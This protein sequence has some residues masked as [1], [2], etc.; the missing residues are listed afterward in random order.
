M[1][2]SPQPA[3][4]EPPHHHYSPKHYHD[5]R[6]SFSGRASTSHS[7]TAHAHPAMRRSRTMATPQYADANPWQHVAKTYAWVLEQQFARMA[8]ENDETVQ[9][10]HQQQ[11]RDAIREQAAYRIV[12][13]GHRGRHAA[14]DVHYGDPYAAME[15]AARRKRRWQREAELMLEEEMQRLQAY[16]RESE[17]HREAFE[18]RRLEE[19]QARARWEREREA[20]RSRRQEAE[21]EAQS[22]YESRWAEL[23]STS[24]SLGFCDIPWPTFAR[25]RSLDDITTAKVTRFVLSP[26][27]PGETRREKVRNALRRWHPD[28]FGRVLARVDEEDR[29]MVEEGVGIVV[30]CLNSLLERESQ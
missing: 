6:A 11:A 5:D 10:I 30:R 21:R 12:A 24:E 9:W 25:P 20:L 19:E 7:S 22:E 18:K 15:E 3:Y 26:L 2:A 23:S 16:R 14:E 4:Y 27:Q 13:S 1:F 8:E 17:R 28:R 29:E